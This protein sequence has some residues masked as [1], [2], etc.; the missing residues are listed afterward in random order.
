MTWLQAA[1]FDDR[2]R[3][4]AFGPDD[5]EHLFGDL[6]GDGAL[7]DQIEDRAE[8]RGRHRR[9][10]D[11]LALA[12]EPTGK[13]VDHPIGGELRVAQRRSRRSADHRL[14]IFGGLALGDEHVGVVSAQ[15]EVGA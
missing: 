14:E 9:C 1:L 7:A 15:R 12:I 6:A 13:L 8:L 4:A 10:R 2:P 5:L 11:I 3:I